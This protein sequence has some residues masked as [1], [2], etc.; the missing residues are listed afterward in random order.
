MIQDYLEAYSSIQIDLEQVFP[1]IAKLCTW[2]GNTA[3]CNPHSETG[4]VYYSLHM[5]KEH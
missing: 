3:R 1:F 4:T 5:K 2:I